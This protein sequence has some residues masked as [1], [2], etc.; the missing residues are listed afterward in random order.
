VPVEDEVLRGHPALDL[1]KDGRPGLVRGRE[2]PK[3]LVRRDQ[4]ERVPNRSV[5]DDAEA[6]GRARSVHE[7]GPAEVELDSFEISVVVV[8]IHFVRASWRAMRR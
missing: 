2:T 3:D 8:R 1:G 6:I 5:D 7:L 4:P